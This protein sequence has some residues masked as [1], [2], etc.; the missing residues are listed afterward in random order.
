M[1]ALI[2]VGGFGTRLRPLT[3]TI[4]KPLVEFG[5]KPM[6]V[7]QIE[8]LVKAGVKDV[9]LAVNYRPEIMVK[10]MKKYEEE[11]NIKIH[12]SVENE[13]LGTAGPLALAAHIL[14]KD[15]E[16]FFV[17]NS[18][19]IC[20]FPFPEM[21]AFHKKHGGE[22]TIMV[23][24]VE[25]PSKYGVVVNRPGSTEIDRFVEKPKDFISNK[26]NAGLY[27]FNPTVLKRILPEPMSIETEVFPP[28]AAEGQIHSM[29]LPGFWMDV[30][31]P[32]DFLT[33]T[34]LWLSSV[35]KKT[36]G[37]LTTGSYITGHV[38]I[39]PSAKIGDNCK[40]G[41]NVTIGPNVIIGD[42]VRLSRS[43]LLD[44]SVVKD[45]AWV[46][47]TIVGWHSTVGRWAR[48]ENVTVLGDD[49][50]VSDEIY[51]NGAK[52]LP[53]KSVSANIGEPTIVM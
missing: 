51:I 9:V 7:H 27:I 4:P 45:H 23:T 8:A 34:G 38:L 35:A 32:K 30:G 20:D 37:S 50:H 28:M 13:P 46:Q 15:D 29:E 47:S 19:V 17:L 6:I 1:K 40:I 5:N 14:G 16:P 48:L 31:Q 26:I 25:E 11:L 52:V 44:G 49:V 2:L 42:G 10:A 39:D 33:G 3:L 43:V 21:V 24:R 53:H 36:P 22:G 18:D 12:F 41:P